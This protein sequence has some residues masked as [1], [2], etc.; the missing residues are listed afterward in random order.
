MSDSD[1]WGIITFGWLS[2]CRLE[3]IVVLNV[4][5]VQASARVCLC[6][7]GWIG[8]HAFVSRHFLASTFWFLTPYV[9]LAL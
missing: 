9:R 2:M 3:L 5:C 8:V 7:R 1:P 4:V 6:V